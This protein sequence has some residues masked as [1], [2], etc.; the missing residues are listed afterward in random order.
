MENAS[1]RYSSGEVKRRIEQEKEKHGWEFLFIGA[2][3]DAVE[4]AKSIGISRD[5]AVGYRADAK[6][7][8]VLYEAVSETVGR[9]RGDKPVE[10]SWG[11]KIEE[12]NKSRK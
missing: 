7:T 10:A 12:D 4:T 11:K 8:Q 6:G 3:I 2:N 9:F 5:R 1:H